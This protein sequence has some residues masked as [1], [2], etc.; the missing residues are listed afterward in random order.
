LRKNE[1]ART[2]SPLRDIRG[3]LQIIL[4]QAFHVFSK[5]NIDIILEKVF[6]PQISQIST[7]YQGIVESKASALWISCG[8]AV[9]DT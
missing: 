8:E 4:L 5:S 2:E 6:E 7:D 3:F 1:E 9:F